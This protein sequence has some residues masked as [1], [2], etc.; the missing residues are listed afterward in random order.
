MA[1]ETLVLP[2]SVYNVLYRLTGASRPDVALSLAIKELAHLK[3]EAAKARVTAFEKK[4]GM[5][6]PAFEKAWE[7]GQ[8]PNRYSYEVETDYQDWEAAVTDTAA[9]EELS[10]WLI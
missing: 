2:K 8:I 5:T 9:L 3:L 6:Y 7:A 10:Q 4:Y 1:T